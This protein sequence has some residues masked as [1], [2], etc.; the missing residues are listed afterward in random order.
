MNKQK[1]LKNRRNNNFSGGFNKNQFIQK[2]KSSQ[3]LTKNE[4]SENRNKRAQRNNQ[5]STQNS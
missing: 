1:Y 5:R 2:R 4:N 3:N